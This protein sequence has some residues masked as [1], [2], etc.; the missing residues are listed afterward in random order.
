MNQ[1]RLHAL[2]ASA[3]TPGDV[4]E[5][6]A[7]LEQR[8]DAAGSGGRFEPVGGFGDLVAAAPGATAALSPELAQGPAP[9]RWL[10]APGDAPAH[11]RLLAEVQM[12]L[13]D[14]DV[15]RRD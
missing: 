3:R 9:E 14:A 5:L 6:F 10:P 8:L 13:Y 2:P 12:C 1:L 4:R 7:W 15:N 11:H